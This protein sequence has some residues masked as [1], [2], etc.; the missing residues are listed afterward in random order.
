[1]NPAPHASPASLLVSLR[2][3]HLS[4][5]LE[6]GKWVPAT[7]FG[8]WKERG[9]ERDSG[10]LERLPLDVSSK[11]TWATELLRKNA[12]I[13]WDGLGSKDELR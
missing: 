4:E 6:V 3:E 9:M 12:S 2:P 5:V 8:G 13:N 10:H 1:M 11:E 7:P